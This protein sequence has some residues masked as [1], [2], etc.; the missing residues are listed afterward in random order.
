MALWSPT[1]GGAP[2]GRGPRGPRPGGPACSPTAA[3]NRPL[4]SEHIPV[5]QPI[6][7]SGQSI[8][9]SVIRRLDQ[10]LAGVSSRLAYAQCRQ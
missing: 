5:R 8:Y 1:N 9:R 2:A 7:R 10:A 3:A 4:R 6:G